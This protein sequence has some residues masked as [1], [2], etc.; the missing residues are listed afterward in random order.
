MYHLLKKIFVAVLLLVT[1]ICAVHLLQTVL[2]QT[3][4]SPD[5]IMQGVDVGQSKTGTDRINR[6]GKPSTSQIFH[7]VA[8]PT[9]VKEKSTKTL[10]FNSASQ[11]VRL[12]SIRGTLSP[13][14]IQGIKNFVFF[15]GF[16]RSGHSI[17]SSIMD[18]HPHMVMSNELQFF[19][20]MNYISERAGP[21]AWTAKLFNTIFQHTTK[22]IQVGGQRNAKANVKGY[23]LAI[24]SSWQ[25]RF[26]EY[27]QVIGDKSAGATTHAYIK[28]K[29]AFRER[30]QEL[31]ENIGIPIKALYVV[32]NPFDTISTRLLYKFGRNDKN[33]KT[34]AYYVAELKKRVGNATDME[35]MKYQNYSLLE[36][37][38]NSYFRTAIAVD[39]L[40]EFIG[41]ENVSIIHLRD[42]IQNPKD[43]I[44]GMTNFLGVEVE[45]D[46]LQVCVDKVFTTASH[47]RNMMAWPSEL[48]MMVEN[49]M[50]NFKIFQGYN[51]FSD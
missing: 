48:R 36:N 24:N 22:D 50:Q 26:D 20:K 4:F 17:V 8:A 3:I 27:I 15:V 29:V 32:R 7:S 42:L 47:S 41:K 1:S 40:I 12:S 21:R 49:K 6:Q 38:I 33:K 9:T 35:K 31:L 46:Y 37:D 14:V 51:F 39:E 28:D 11:M 25:G 44:L 16:I 18:A 5:K 43:V 10:L 23:T 45:D 19:N 13:N 30:Y 2:H 34:G